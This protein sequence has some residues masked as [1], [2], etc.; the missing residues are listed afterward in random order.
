MLIGDSQSLERGLS[1]FGGEMEELREALDH[2]QEKTLLL[3]DEIASGTNPKEG[4]AL[5]KGLVSYLMAKPYIC[6]I[7]THFDSVADLPE[8]VNLQV[9]G[10]AQADFERLRREL[11]YANRKERIQLIAKHMDYQLRVV[12]GSGDVPKEAIHIAEILGLYPEIIQEA[13]NYL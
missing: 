13:K 1:S 2:S 7:T 11:R 8:V 4:T 6:L 12:K 5:S 9:I 10:L 3:I